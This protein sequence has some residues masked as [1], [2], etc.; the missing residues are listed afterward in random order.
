MTFSHHESLIASGF[1][2]SNAGFVESM[3][4]LVSISFSMVGKEEGVGGGGIGYGLLKKR[5]PHVP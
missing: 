2:P 3:M 5:Q 4:L 1:W